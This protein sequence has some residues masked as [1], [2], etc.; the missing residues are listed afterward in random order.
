VIIEDLKYKFQKGLSLVEG[1]TAAAILGA[2]ITVFMTLQSTQEQDFSTLRKFDKAAYAVELM[3]E[4]LAAVYQPIASQYGNPQVAED[5]TAG[6]TLKA[7]GFNQLPDVGDEIII[8]GVGGKYEITARSAF[9]SDQNTILTLDRSDIADDNIVNMASDA[10]LNANITIVSNAQGSLDPYHSLDL[11]K[12]D[13]TAYIT[14]LEDND[15]EKVATDLQNWG[16]L[17]EK[18]LGPS[19]TGDKRLIEVVDITKD[20]PLDLDNDGVTDTDSEGDNIIEQI[21]KKQV[22][23]IIK[24]D[25]IEEKFRRLFLSGT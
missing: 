18:H 24:Q 15:L 25:N 22:T 14:N 10:A 20:V 13:D 16:A 5:T 7:K 23:I 9:D 6:V 4:E 8:T 3:F 21:K 19:R 2:S 11:T 12:H 17:L 1:M